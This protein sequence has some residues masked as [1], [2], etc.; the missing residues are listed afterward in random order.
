MQIRAKRIVFV[1]LVLAASGAADT[2]VLKNGR[3]LY[4][5]QV[6]EVAGRIEYEVGDNSYAIPK[7]SVDHVEKG[8]IAPIASVSASVASAA[9]T[10]L[11][12]IAATGTVKGADAMTARV[13]KDGHVDIDALLAADQPNDPETAAAAYFAAGKFEQTHGN[14]EKARLY[15]NNALSRT[16]TNGT[17]LEHYV[18]VLIQMHRFAEAIPYAQ[19]AVRLGPN[20]AD[21]HALLGYAYF[22]S[23][24]TKEAIREWE[25]ALA[26]QNDPSVRAWLERAKRELEAE[27]GFGEQESGHFTI[28]YEGAQAPAS[29]RAA[30]LSTLEFHYNDLVREFGISPRQNILVSLYTGQAFFDVTHAPSWTAAQNDGKLRIPIEGLDT[31]TSDLSRVLKHELAHSFI[32]QITRNRCPTWL[33]EG[34]A[35]AVEPQ[36]A[37]PFGAALAR[38]YGRGGQVPLN[39][40]EGSFNGLDTQMAAIAYGESLAAVEYIQQTYGMSDTVR[41]LQRIG[42]GA[43]TESA[44]RATIHSG[45]DSFEGEIGQY[46]KKT[47]GTD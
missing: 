33:N 30:I 42:E 20:S 47:Y 18:A 39:L 38:L 5:D 44:M 17:I 2:I 4:A 45:Y 32:A 36:T 41:I 19:Q 15:F 7:S 31:V 37:A 46:L 3:K 9:D 34:I 27:E 24:K 1:L 35:Q 13:V 26:L 12:A 6:R 16:P 23:E 14:P 25:K 29:L 28:R 40:L 43:S 8:G 10:E 22:N 21:A 11:P